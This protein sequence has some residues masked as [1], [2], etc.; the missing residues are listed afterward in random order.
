MSNLSQFSGGGI[1]S[2]QR[3]T[4]TV[5]TSAGLATGTATITSVSTSKSMIILLGTRFTAND[6]GNVNCRLELTNSTT[7]TAYVNAAGA[8]LEIGYQVVEFY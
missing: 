4:I 6:Y 1:K 2:I 8:A 5:T 7:V 3:G